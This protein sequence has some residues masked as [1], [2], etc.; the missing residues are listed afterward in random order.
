MPNV[1]RAMMAAS[2]NSADPGQELFTTAGADTWT[3]P[4]GVTS[5]SVICVGGGG[6]GG[7]SDNATKGGGAGGGGELTRTI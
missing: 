7:G 2:Y 1:R 5:V 3:C 4:N 6:G